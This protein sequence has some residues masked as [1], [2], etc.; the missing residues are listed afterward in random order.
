MAVTDHLMRIPAAG[1][2]L[3]ALVA[4]LPFGRAAEAGLLLIVGLALAQRD[5]RAWRAPLGVFA[6][7]WLPMLIALID[8]NAFAESAQSTFGYLR[9]GLLAAAI[10]VLMN[11]TRLAQIEPLV[12]IVVALWTL[13]ALI[14]SVA[15]V[16]LFGMPV[17]A[18]RLSGVFGADN[19]KLG[20]VLAVLGPI[21]LAV[22]LRYSRP[23]AAIA[24]LLLSAAILLAGTRSAWV[25]WLLVLLAF[26]VWLTPGSWA[27]RVGA[28]AAA[29]G[30]MLLVGLAALQLSPPFAER[31]ERTAQALKG[32]TVGVDQA[33]AGRLPIWQTALAM[34]EAHPMNGVGVR[35]FRHAYP[36]YAADGD[37]WVDRDSATGAAHPHQLGLELASETGAIGVIGGLALAIVLW[38]F[39]RAAAPAARLAAQPYAAA[40]IALQ[41]PFN[42]HLAWFSSFW[43]LI[44]WLLMGLY[45]AALTRR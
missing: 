24:A 36:A 15:G 11:P 22:A 6:L 4:L 35:G 37:P 41:F 42:T 38:R 21:V 7:L 39:W 8:A 19:L 45:L 23:L 14:Q 43:G 5:W 33:L 31:I 9:F 40:L 27:R 3:L 18:D 16:N 34:A 26:G 29:L 10:V 25:Q 20:P 44:V 1:W 17:S 13:D 2:S 28:I 32:D 12:A 30:L